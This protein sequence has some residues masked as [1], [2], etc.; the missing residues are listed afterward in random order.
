MDRRP[1]PRVP[2]H[3][4]GAGSN[5]NRPQLTDEQATT[6]TVRH[7]LAGDDGWNPTPH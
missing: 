7:Y 5:D 1:L 3:R 6:Y 2:Q 4:P